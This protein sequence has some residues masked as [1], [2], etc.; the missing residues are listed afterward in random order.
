MLI[1]MLITWKLGV[2]FETVYKKGLLRIVR[3]RNQ[4]DLLLTIIE[5]Q[6]TCGLCEVFLLVECLFGFFFPSFASYSCYHFRSCHHRVYTDN[7]LIHRTRQTSLLNSTPA[8]AQTAFFFLGVE[9]F[10]SC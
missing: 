5:D 6:Q 3:L 8:Q 4:R 1:T 7:N 9:T 2:V 10:F